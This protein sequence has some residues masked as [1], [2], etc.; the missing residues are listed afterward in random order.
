MKANEFTDKQKELLKLL[1][2]REYSRIELRNMGYRI[3]EQFL[4][5]CECQGV[6]IYE[7]KQTLGILK[8]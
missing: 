6:P 4:L 1:E 3:T 2:I 5:T 7:G 8:R